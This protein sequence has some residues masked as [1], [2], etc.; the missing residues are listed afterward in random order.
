M[1][2]KKSLIFKLATFLLAFAPTVVALNSCIAGLFGE[3]ELPAKM[4]RKEL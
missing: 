2:K 4:Q 1:N 3:P